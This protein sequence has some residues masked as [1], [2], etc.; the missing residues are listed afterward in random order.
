MRERGGA[1]IA[2]RGARAI[3]GSGERGSPCAI[4]HRMTA[5]TSGP[6]RSAAE[7][8]K[9]DQWLRELLEQKVCFN[10]V[11]GLRSLSMSLEAP[12]IRFDMRPELVGHFA[13][14]RLHGGVIAA[15]LDAL[16]GQA[17]TIGIAHRHPSESA[18]Q[19]MHRFNRVGTIDL[20]VDYLR[21]GVGK[22]FVATA[23]ILRMGGRIATTQ[24]WLEN[25][26]AQTIAMAIGAYTVS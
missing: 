5:H 14:G 19:V 15:A 7:Q 16:G 3:I 2:R 18:E 4:I 6:P 9:L 20:R 1:R 21:P 12:S 17:V 13:Y 26:E 23:K 11:L 8:A 24:M 10:A 25:D 22:H